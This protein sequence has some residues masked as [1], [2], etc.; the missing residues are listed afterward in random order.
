MLRI[1]KISAAVIAVTVGVFALSLYLFKGAGFVIGILIC[2][3]IFFSF[4]FISA[5]NEQIYVTKLHKKGRRTYGKITNI[6]YASRSVNYII[7]YQADGKDY[8][9]ESGRKFGKWEI[10]YDK[11]PL[12]YDPERPENVCLE[13]YDLVSAISDI[14]VLSVL[15]A[16]FIGL[17]IYVIILSI[18]FL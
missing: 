18:Q 11:M 7:S 6:V 16:V 1:L 8:K 4:L 15:E 14:V 17:T 2:A 10:G 12:L 13:K 3:D 5:I 9:F